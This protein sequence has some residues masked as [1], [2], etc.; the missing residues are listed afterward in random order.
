MNAEVHTTGGLRA[1]LPLAPGPEDHFR[2]R[3][4]AVTRVEGFT[5][6]V[7]AFAVTL[8]VVALEVP[9]TFDGLMNVVRAFPAFVICFAVLM[10]FWNAHYRFYRRYGFEDLFSRLM[11]L[12]ILVLVLFS[13]YP[14]KY[15]FTLVT[16]GVFDLG[17]ANAPT[18]SSV[19]EV[20]MLY[21][22]YGLGF[23][24]VWSLYALLYWHALRQRAALGLSAVEVLITRASFA[25][26][27][28]HVG[29]C[30]G[31]IALAYATSNAWLPGVFYAILGPVQALNGWLYGR[32][33]RV[34]AA[35]AG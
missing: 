21:L 12:A 16:N 7:F 11:T 22:V 25:E 1:Q 29:A 28:I 20:R 14:L 6:S 33:M 34:A 17:I 19:G 31:S 23:A 32:K 5:D 4:N 9:N 30:L 27:L 10:I 35:T 2:W 26:Y 24:G 13:V 15:L 8:L 18:L 3:G